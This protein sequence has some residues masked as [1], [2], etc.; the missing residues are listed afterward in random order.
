MSGMGPEPLDLRGRVSKERLPEVE[1]EL[2]ERFER[3]GLQIMNRARAGSA[4]DSD[5]IGSV[6]GDPAK[7]SAAAQILG[8]AY[9][10]AVCCMR[11]NREA[12]AERGR[13]ARPAQG[14]LRRRG[15][16]A[17]AARRPARARHRRPR[18]G[19]LAQGMSETRRRD[20][21]AAPLGSGGHAAQAR[22][23]LAPARAQRAAAAARRRRRRVRRDR[24]RRAATCCPSATPGRR[25]RRGRRRR[26]SAYAPRFQFMTGALVAVGIAALAGSPWRSSASRPST[27]A[28]VVGL[29][30]RRPAAS[31][32]P[33][34][35]PATSPPPTATS[36]TQ[37]VKVDG[38][39]ISYKGVPLLVALRKSRRRGRRHP[40]PRREG[41]ALPA[42]RPEAD[43]RDRPRQAVGRAR[44]P[45]APRGARARALLVRYLD[46]KQVVVLIP[47][48][49][50]KVQTV[51]L[52]FQ[53]DDVR[54]S[55]P[56]R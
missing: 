46:V 9:L 29:G 1:K 42:L 36:G 20:H 27:K 3:I 25:P 50:G 14:A 56:G 43:L 22:S 16:R 2:M 28:R 54:P 5:P 38:Q 40:G 45:D 24:R 33:R 52:Y 34:R 47:P 8:Q 39:R 12:V 17:A 18:R 53:R 32:A 37:L 55:S 19:H 48:P 6:L 49:P 26:A 21:S 35:S 30:S 4:M 51:A 10:T 44:L 13:R 41:R 31:R 15:R 11:A 23:R 7:R